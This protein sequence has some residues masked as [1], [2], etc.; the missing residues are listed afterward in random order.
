MQEAR[1]LEK[2]TDQGGRMYIFRIHR[3][4][5]L[6]ETGTQRAELDR[7]R[8]VRVIQVTGVPLVRLTHHA[9]DTLYD[10]TYVFSGEQR[11]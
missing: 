8:P 7:A 10:A 11:S 2:T 5:P 1:Q 6:Q 9:N 4:W 3:Q